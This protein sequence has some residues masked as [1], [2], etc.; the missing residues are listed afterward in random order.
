VRWD[1]IRQHERI[2]AGTGGR[3]FIR[4]LDFNGCPD[5][6]AWPGLIRGAVAPLTHRYPGYPNYVAPEDRGLPE[7]YRA[8]LRERLLLAAFAMLAGLAGWRLGTRRE[9]RRS[10]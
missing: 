3:Y 6:Q 4:P 1:A 9:V 8:V 7:W 2:V 5:C 10:G